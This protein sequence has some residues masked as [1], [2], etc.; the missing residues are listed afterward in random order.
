MRVEGE[1][2]TRNG[3]AS[4]RCDSTAHP[5]HDS[6]LSHG[7]DHILHDTS[8]L[9]FGLR[10]TRPRIGI[11]WHCLTN[12]D[13]CITIYWRRKRRQCVKSAAHSDDNNNG[14]ER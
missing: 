14:D 10:A 9:R 11:I 5:L 4:S 2:E 6:S 12:Q 1:S 3:E 13:N 7:L 8:E